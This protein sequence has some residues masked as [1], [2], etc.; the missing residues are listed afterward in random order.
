MPAFITDYNTPGEW[1]EIGAEWVAV[2]TFYADAAATV[3]FDWTDYTDGQ[4]QIRQEQNT[5]SALYLD[6]VDSGGSVVFGGATG[7]VTYTI[8]DTVSATQTWET[9]F[10]QVEATNPSGDIERIQQGEIATN[11]RIYAES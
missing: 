7:T 3:P 6:I 2:V 10:Y 8:P 1:V 5:T 11:A 9:G 4:F